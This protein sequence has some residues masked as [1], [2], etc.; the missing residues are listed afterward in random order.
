[1]SIKEIQYLNRDFCVLFS[2]PL[3]YLHYVTF[4]DKYPNANY[5]YVL[6]KEPFT[7]ETT[8]ETII[9]EFKTYV[10][11]IIN[12]SQLCRLLVFIHDFQIEYPGIIDDIE[13]Y[14]NFSVTSYNISNNN[15]SFPDNSIVWEINKI[16]PKICGILFENIISYILEIKDKCY[17]LS[18]C[19]TSPSS[20]IPKKTIEGILER[21]FIK[22]NLLHRGQQIRINNKDIIYIGDKKIEE[23]DFISLWHYLIFLSLK[24]FLKRDFVGEDLEDCLKILDYVNINVKYIDDYYYDMLDSTFIKNLKRETNLM[25]GEIFRTKEMHGEID[26]LSDTSI[27]DIKS[28]KSDNIDNWF[29]QLYL[30]EKLVG[31]R[32]TLKILNVYNNQVFEFKHD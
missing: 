17:D 15:D 30:Y 32:K 25:H 2:K 24:H 4:M 8:E 12:V 11:S 28:Y 3:V 20:N 19:M 31:K 29:A 5:Q 14:P 13:T 27:I 23:D 1:M 21:N 22:R 26:F 16:S 10:G 9:T 7:A 18:N 6:K